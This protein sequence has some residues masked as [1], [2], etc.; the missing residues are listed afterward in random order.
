MTGN[1]YLAKRKAAALPDVV[2]NLEV[3]E[4]LSFRAAEIIKHLLVFA[5]RDIVQKEPFGL[6]SY[7]KEITKLNRAAIPSSITF[8]Q[9]F[10]EQELVINGDA[11]QLQQVLLNLLSN[12][13]DAVAMVE[14]P[15]IRLTVELFSADAAFSEQYPDQEAKAFAHLIV[16]DNG[17]GISNEARTHIFE[18]FFTTKKVG[19]GTGLGLA[20]AYGAIQQH[21]GMIE[22]DNNT[23][24]GVS[25]HIYLPIVAEEASPIDEKPE[26]VAAGKG[27]TIL[28]ADDDADVR[29][30]SKKVLESLGYK[31]LEAVDGI[32][33]FDKFNENCEAIS[34]IIMDIVM[35]RLSGVKVAE[36][37]RAAHPEVK[38]I[39]AS[40]YD[41]DELNKG[42]MPP[43]EYI[44]LSKPYPVEAVNS[45]IRELLDS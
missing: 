13:R 9:Q 40:G 29:S 44:I 8:N 24:P 2:S 7:I 10:C 23:G 4:T 33:A 25:V 42:A 17:C 43:A 11:P 39:F 18:P 21:D 37:I 1:L 3:V 31:V 14:E 28:I 19:V 27:E 41:R 26:P 12:A 15:E 5:R 30:A 38:I 20:M 36:R 22:V 6:V 16:E 34:L 32:D 45:L 35:P